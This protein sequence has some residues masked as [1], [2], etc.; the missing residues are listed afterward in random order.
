[1]GL[2]LA[3]VKHASKQCE[4]TS[5][6][7][8]SPCFPPPSLLVENTTLVFA[9]LDHPPDPSI[10]LGREQGRLVDACSAGQVAHCYCCILSLDRGSKE[11]RVDRLG[12][13]LQVE[14][15]SERAAEG[16]Q[17]S[18]IRLSY[19]EAAPTHVCFLLV[20]LPA[21]PSDGDVLL[22][23]PRKSG[24]QLLVNHSAQARRIT[25]ASASC[26][27]VALVLDVPVQRCP[28]ALEHLVQLLCAVEGDGR[29]CHCCFTAADIDAVAVCHR[30]CTVVLVA[31][32]SAL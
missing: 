19:E 12:G 3:G 27:L 4:C 23:V 15:A 31:V 14:R 22:D 32:A 25:I 11:G 18:D 20:L 21:H 2:A 10:D 6:N 26:H 28:D 30:R 1:M 17:L 7:D 29:C 16:P 5:T 8:T 9:A 13:C 24:S